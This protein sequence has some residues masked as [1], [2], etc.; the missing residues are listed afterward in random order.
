MLAFIVGIISIFPTRLC[1]LGS[2]ADLV[3]LINLKNLIN[4][5]L[6]LGILFG[7]FS[8]VALFFFSLFRFIR[9]YDFIIPSLR[10]L[11]TFDEDDWKKLTNIF[12]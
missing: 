6:R 4:Y 3:P 11:V 12:K 1:F 9:E 8:S 10:F 5:F 7:L 2:C